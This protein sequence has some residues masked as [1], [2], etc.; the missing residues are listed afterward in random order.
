MQPPALYA[1]RRAANFLMLTLSGL[2]MAIGV[3]ALAWIL[4]TLV[5]RGLSGLTL[6]TFTA[7]TPPPGSDGGLLNAIVGSLEMVATAILIGAPIGVLAGT[8]LAEFGR[9]RRVAST[10]RFLNDIL[11]SRAVDHRRTVRLRSDR[12]AN[13]TLLGLGGGVRPGAHQL[14]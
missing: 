9:D 4:W 11:L 8:Y 10:V 7:T 1:R 6:E 14:R 3:A 5:A 2:S 12:G 13:E